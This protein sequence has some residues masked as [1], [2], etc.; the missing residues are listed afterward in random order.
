MVRRMLHLLRKHGGHG[1]LR[2]WT[3]VS[4]L[5]LRPQAQEDVQR[6]LSHL[7]EADQGHHQDLPQ[8]IKGRNDELNQETWP[9]EPFPKLVLVLWRGLFLIRVSL[10]WSCTVVPLRAF[11]KCLLPH[12]EN[13]QMEKRFENFSHWLGHVVWFRDRH[14]PVLKQMSHFRAECLICRSFRYWLKLWNMS[15]KG[16]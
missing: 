7:Q 2:L 3:H 12:V 6:L 11:Q 13:Y 16:F 1:H 10:W 5:H 15:S 9:Q 4:V 8:H 14:P